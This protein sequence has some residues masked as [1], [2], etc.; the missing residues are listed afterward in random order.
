MPHSTV[1]FVF[2]MEAVCSDRTHHIWDLAIQHVCTG[3]TFHRFIDPQLETYPQPPNPALFHVTST[4][5]KEQQA[6]PFSVVVRE[7]IHWV[8]TFHGTHFVF[9]SHGCFVLDKPLLELEFGRLNMVIPTTWYFFDTLPFLR[10]KYKKQPS[11]A[12]GRLYNVMF[13]KKIEHAH[14]AMADT[15]ALRKMILHCFQMPVLPYHLATQIH[16]CYYPAFYTPLQ[17]VRYIGTYNEQ[18]LVLGGV[19][20]VEDLYMLLRQQCRMNVDRLQEHLRTTFNVRASDAL[21]I[22]NSI[23]TMLLQ[24]D[25]KTNRLSSN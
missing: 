3:Q 19:Q 8:Q 25:G 9:M 24:P 20:C 5:L 4:F 10:N 6:Q 7:L 16:G 11:Y 22:S 2:D 13:G 17:C 21:K 18:L 14:W 15:L 1:H 23:L 12:L